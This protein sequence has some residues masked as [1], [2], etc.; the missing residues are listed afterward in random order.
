MVKEITT[1]KDK[2]QFLPEATYENNF[3][4]LFEPCISIELLS[5]MLSTIIHHLLLTE[6]VTRYFHARSYE[7]SF[8]Q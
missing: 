8:K 7:N 5:K 4:L 6:V 3:I 2:S 1:N